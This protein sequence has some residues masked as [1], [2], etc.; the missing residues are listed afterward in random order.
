METY[1]ECLGSNSVLQPRGLGS[2]AAIW[3]RARRRPQPQVLGSEGDD[4]EGGEVRWQVQVGEAR[5]GR[6]KRVRQVVDGR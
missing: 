2:K 5:E 1:P 6:G 4:M 3:Q